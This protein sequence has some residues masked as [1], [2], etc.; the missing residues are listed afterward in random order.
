MLCLPKD[1]VTETPKTRS[2]PPTTKKPIPKKN[3]ITNKTE[4]GLIHVD[5]HV[6]STNPFCDETY[7]KPNERCGGWGYNG[8]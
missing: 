3:L 7:A 8:N 2:I 5:I 1:Y 4:D 6:D